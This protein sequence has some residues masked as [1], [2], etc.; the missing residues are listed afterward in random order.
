MHPYELPECVELDVEA[1]SEEYLAWIA[2]EASG[3]K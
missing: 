1:G 3:G 2:A